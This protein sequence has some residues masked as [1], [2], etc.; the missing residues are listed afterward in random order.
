MRIGLDFDNTIVS[1]DSLFHKI[2]CDWGA[3]PKNIQV[4]KVAIRD[5]LRSV[6]LE[7][8]WTEMQG[9]AYGKCMDQAVAYAGVINFLGWARD[10]GHEVFVISHKTQ[11]P[12]SGPQYDLRQAA[13]DWIDCHL[14]SEGKPLIH[15]ANIF[16]ENTK[17]EKLFR[18]ALTNCNWFL[19]DLPEILSASGFSIK[20]RG[21][22]F[23]PD[24]NHEVEVFTTFLRVHSWHEF[25]AVLMGEAS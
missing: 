10:K 22:L 16:Y 21:V 13:T 4:N 15:K 23:D 24:K 12:F 8:V 9:F 6:G 11:F 3:I 18:I 14:V 17:Q 19:D 5:Y 25:L 20:T 1:Y 7:S 2:A